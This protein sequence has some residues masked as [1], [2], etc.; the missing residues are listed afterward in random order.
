[1]EIQDTWEW[2]CLEGKI[3][4]EVLRAPRTE[5]DPYSKGWPKVAPRVV[6][7]L[8]K[9]VVG[10]PWAD[11]V[12]LVAAVM[13]ARRYDQASVDKVTTTLHLRFIQFFRAGNLQKMEE[14]R[15]EE[16]IRAYLRGEIALKD[17]Q[18]MR[19]DFWTRYFTA[20]KLIW[21]WIEALP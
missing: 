3:A 2:S 9:H 7:Y 18:S 6:M 20:T 14:W 19:T 13:T 17:S 11:H 1:K 21:L 4:P 12:A 10:H 15:A 5:G 16:T 8:A